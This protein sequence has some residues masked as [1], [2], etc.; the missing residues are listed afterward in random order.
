MVKLQNQILVLFHLEG[1]HISVLKATYGEGWCRRVG[2]TCVSLS[3]R[4][5]S[6]EKGEHRGGDYAVVEDD[7]LL[8]SS[9][10]LLCCR[11][12]LA[13]FRDDDIKPRWSRVLPV[14]LGCSLLFCLFMRVLGCACLG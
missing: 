2:C 5:R 10:R 12:L 1:A 4:C 3:F 7:D 13:R 9:C 8:G 11:G 6:E 14:V